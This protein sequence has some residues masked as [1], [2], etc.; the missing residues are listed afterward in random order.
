M[1]AMAPVAGMPPN[2]PAATEAS[3]CPTSSR[4]ASNGP[5][6]EIVAATSAESSDSM[7]ASA[8]T[9]SA[10]ATRFMISAG[11]A[12]GSPGAGNACGSEPIRATGAWVRAHARVTTTM[13]MIEPGIFRCTRAAAIITIATTAAL[14]S[15]HSTV[16]AEAIPT[17]CTAARTAFSPCG[18]ATP[19]ADGTCCRKMITAMPSVKPSITGHGMELTVRPSFSSPTSRTT[20]PAMIDTRAIAAAPCVATMGPRTTTMAPVGP[21]TCTWDPPKTAATTPA[22]IAVIR[23]ASA[24]APLLTPKARAS[25]RA[26]MPTVSPASR[27]PRQ[28][29]GTS[30]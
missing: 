12:G 11:S 30:R 16:G 25:G 1:R 6:S 22:T 7:A 29:R 26:T 13:P 23:P 20:S 4:S 2:K 21:E 28:V 9:V 27:S 8:A 14:P 3:P 15:V 19:T 10:A 18:I 17:A 5:V 24:P